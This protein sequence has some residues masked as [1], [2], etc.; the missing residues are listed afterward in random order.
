M[1]LGFKPITLAVRHKGA[2]HC[3]TEKNQNTI[4]DPSKIASRCSTVRNVN[5]CG[6][7]K[8]TFSGHWGDGTL[9]AHMSPIKG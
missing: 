2:T 6:V 4:N 7:S 5:V 1:E 8:S 9:I 3:G